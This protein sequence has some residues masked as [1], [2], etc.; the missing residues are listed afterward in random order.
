MTR[1]SLPDA[2]REACDL[3]ETLYTEMTALDAVRRDR[4]MVDVSGFVDRL[5]ELRALADAA[6]ARCAETMTFED[7]SAAVIDSLA[8]EV[9]ELRARASVLEAG[10]R[11]ALDRLETERIHGQ[12]ASVVNRL[13]ALLDGGKEGS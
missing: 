2:L 4:T 13:R 6:P 10:L 9:R 5:A 1:P 8:A 11:E 12:R 3:A 7:A